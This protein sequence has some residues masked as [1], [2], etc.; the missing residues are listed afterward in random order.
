MTK[1]IF[2]HTVYFWLNE[3]TTDQ[4]RKSFEDGLRKLGTSS[5]SSGFFWGTPLDIPDR[6]VVDSSYDYAATSFFDSVEQHHV[7][8]NT[9]PIHLDFIQS[10]KHIWGDVKVYDHQIKK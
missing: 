6:D 2:I 7:Y 9:D 10:H 1:A 5:N 3:G 8:Q 4:E